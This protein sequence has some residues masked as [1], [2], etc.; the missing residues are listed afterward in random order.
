MAHWL[1]GDEL[2]VRTHVAPLNP[3]QVTTAARHARTS[4]GSP[5]PTPTCPSTPTGPST[6]PASPPASTPP[7]PPPPITRGLALQP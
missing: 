6:A 7:A 5:S 2:G 3:R 4:T 1:P